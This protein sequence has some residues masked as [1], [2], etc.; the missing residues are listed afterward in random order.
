M[1]VVVKSS[2]SESVN[3]HTKLFSLVSSC[4]EGFSSDL[5][6]SHYQRV[7]EFISHD[8]ELPGL[9]KLNSKKSSFAFADLFCGA[10]GLSLGFELEGA[11]CIYASDR[12]A[13]AIKTF[14]IN[15]PKLNA[16]CDD[17]NDVLQNVTHFDSIPVVIGGP[18]C[19]GFSNANKQR[20]ANDD[21]NLLYQSFLKF[22]DRSNAQVILIENVHGILTVWENIKADLKSKGFISNFLDLEA[23]DFG[24]PQRR[25]R[26]FIV[27]LKGC[28]E[29]EAEA[30]FSELRQN[31]FLEKKNSTFTLGDA[32]NGLP[33][34][35]AK[36]VP[37]KTN[38]ENE[39]FGYS[40]SEE[41]KH[42]NAYT[43]LINHD[44]GTSPLFNHRSK[45]NNSRDIEI[46]SCL[47][48]GGGVLDK[49]FHSLNP[50]KNRDHIFKD[51]F[52]RLSD[53][54]LSKTV[55]AHMYYDCHMYVHPNQDRGLSP[56][57]AARIQGYPDQYIFLGKPNEWYRQI[58][59]SVS[60]L[61]A[62]VIASALIPLIE[63]FIK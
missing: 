14:K 41:C 39:T 51:K 40:I 6:K 37:N 52:H 10:G 20:K 59:N 1:S 63:N 24:F 3:C 19:Q 44:L 50:Y 57:E 25:R 15:R 56:R 2:K 27:G 47:K 11:N 8:Y 58:G 54:D 46:Y 42:T 35:R 23:S 43:K 28:G 62:R 5:I 26:V 13:A 29:H 4:Y 34:L 36:D 45:F 61:V 30:F 38:L 31:I 16:V 53:T 18:P 17:I 33:I 55:T 22:A 49:K 21:R 48:A 9:K 60:P 7:K 32:V 12:D